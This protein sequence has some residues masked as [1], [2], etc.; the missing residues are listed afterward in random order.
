MGNGEFRD[1]NPEDAL[2]YLDQWAENAQH[3]NTVGTFKLKNKP[4]PSLSGGGIHN[5]R[6]N[7]DLKEKFVS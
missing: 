6:E 2:Y 4:Q 3:W 7:H 1:K 5:L